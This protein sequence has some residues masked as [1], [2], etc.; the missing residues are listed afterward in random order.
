M[1][2]DV[3]AH[4]I[5]QAFS[6]FMGDRVSPP[7]GVSAPTGIASHPV[8]VSQADIQGRLELMDAAGVAMQILSP[9]R[10]PYLPDEAECV[11]ASLRR[12]E[13]ARRDPVRAS[14]GDRSVLTGDL[15]LTRFRGHR[16]VCV[17][18]VHDG[19]DKIALCT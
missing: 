1:I 3:N 15:K 8:S 7:V 14:V 2:C 10:P 9:H 12:V 4:Y 11:R 5:L 13:P 6:D 16:T 18:G 17:Q 19:Q